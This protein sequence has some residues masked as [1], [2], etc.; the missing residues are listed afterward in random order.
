MTTPPPGYGDLMGRKD[1]IEDFLERIDDTNRKV[2]TKD[3]LN[4]FPHT[5]ER[6]YLRQNFFRRF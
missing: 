6:Y 1:D 2:S 4:Q 3:F 5:G